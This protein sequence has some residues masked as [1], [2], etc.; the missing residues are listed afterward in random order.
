MMDFN[1]KGNHNVLYNPGLLSTVTNSSTIT[2][3]SSNASVASSTISSDSSSDPYNMSFLTDNQTH[4]TQLMDD[5]SI[6]DNIYDT[7]GFESESSL[8][9][10]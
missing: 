5:L 6:I 7:F 4:Y 3:T 8:Y 1:N 2:N 10:K 9:G